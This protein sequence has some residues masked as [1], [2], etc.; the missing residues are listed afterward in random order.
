VSSAILKWLGGND[1]GAS[2]KAL[3]LA[4]LGEMPERPSYPSDGSDFGRCHRL[5]QAAPEARAGLEKLEVDG[6]PYWAA[7]AS[8]WDE[9]TTAYVDEVERGARGK[10]YELMKSILRPIEDADRSFVR[11]GPR[12]SMRFGG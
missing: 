12:V 10:T 7:L 2:S 4:A 3:A 1:T 9:I 8:R 11:L 5:L 6:G